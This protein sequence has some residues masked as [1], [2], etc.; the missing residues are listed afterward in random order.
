MKKNTRTKGTP[1]FKAKVAAI[2]SLREQAT[3]PELAKQFG[4]HPNRILQP[5]SGSSSRR[6]PARSAAGRRPRAKGAAAS[7][8]SS[9]SGRSVS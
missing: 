8:R 1:E 6:Q 2:A 9:C 3:V 5:G 7:A 4:V